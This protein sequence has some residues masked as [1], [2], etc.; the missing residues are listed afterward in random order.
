MMKI[1]FDLVFVHGKGLDNLIDLLKEN[2]RFVFQ[3]TKRKRGKEGFSIWQHK[4]QATHRGEVR[5]VQ[6]EG[7]FSGEI[8][9]RS[10]G[11]LT[12]AFLGW[13]VRNARDMIYRLDFRME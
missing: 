7:T 1:S 13:I 12:G 3:V 8:R 9:D 4:Q 5:L 2:P 11:M 6:S 10:N